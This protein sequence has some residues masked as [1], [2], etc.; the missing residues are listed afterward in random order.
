MKYHPDEISQNLFE[1]KIITG[2]LGNKKYSKFY[3]K[4]NTK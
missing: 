4:I 1:V 3:L 2:F